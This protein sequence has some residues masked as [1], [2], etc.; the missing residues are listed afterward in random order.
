MGS[1]VLLWLQS[2]T[3]QQGDNMDNLID[4]SMATILLTLTGFSLYLIISVI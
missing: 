1:M 3:Q 4:H 2:K